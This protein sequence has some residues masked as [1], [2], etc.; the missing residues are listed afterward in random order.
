M[1]IKFSSEKIDDIT[2]FLRRI[3]ISQI[4]RFSYHDTGT[5]NLKPKV[6]RLCHSI[7]YDCLRDP[8]VACKGPRKLKLIPKVFCLHLFYIDYLVSNCTPGKLIDFYN[9]QTKLF[10]R[11]ADKILNKLSSECYEGYFTKFAHGKG[12]RGDM[13]KFLLLKVKT[14]AARKTFQ[15]QG[16]LE[17]DNL[18]NTIRMEESI[19]RFKGQC[20]EFFSL[21]CK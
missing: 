10:N 4:C 12:T 16:T 18:P 6:S 19:L 1:K 14:E 13:N 11:S 3:Q 15:F 17:Y 8:T 2:N 21:P 20:K 7:E 9:N 5:L